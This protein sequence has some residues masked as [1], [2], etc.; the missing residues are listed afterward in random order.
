MMKN[1]LRNSIFWN[2][3]RK[4]KILKKHQEVSEFW[5]P[6]IEKYYNGTLPLFKIKKKKNITDEKIIWQYWGQGIC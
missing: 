3:V 4:H 2:K 5:A 6:I 1:L